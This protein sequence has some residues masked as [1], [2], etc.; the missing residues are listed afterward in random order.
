[1]M[2]S[3]TAKIPTMPC[4]IIVRDAERSAG[5]KTPNIVNSSFLA[6][7]LRHEIE[8]HAACKNG[9]DLTGD[10]RADRVHEKMVLAVR[11]LTE[12]LDHARGHREGGNA[13]RA[14][15]RVDLGLREEIQKLSKHHACDRI[16]HERDKTERHDDERAEV[17]KLLCDHAEGNR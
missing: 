12:L 10:V 9:C 16:E 7:H 13:C 15:H 4:H 1:M 2:S 17:D 8:D 14:D 3:I 5:L 6:E 11:L